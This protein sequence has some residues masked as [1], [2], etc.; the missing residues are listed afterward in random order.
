MTD[1]APTAHPHAAP[2]PGQATL[3]L[4]EMR[5]LA[6][7]ARLDLSEAESAALLH[8]LNRMLGY[9]RK[10]QELDT[11]GVEEMQ[12][13]TPLLNVLRDDLPG[14]MFSQ[15]EALSLAP[16]TRDGF[17]QVPRTVEQDQ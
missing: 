7:L 6:R 15:A 16:E 5:H 8:D 14:A 4:G 11:E 3:D 2:A 1:P 17:I 9:F 12:R 13:P 10:L